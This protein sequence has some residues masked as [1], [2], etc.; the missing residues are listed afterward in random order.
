[1]K[2]KDY[3]NV[4]LR[5]Q[6]RLNDFDIVS[7]YLTRATFILRGLEALHWRIVGFSLIQLFPVLNFVN[8]V[9]QNTFIHLYLLEEGDV[10]NFVIVYDGI[11]I[12]IPPD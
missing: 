2:T 1:M 4:L 8:N 10:V 11:A 5:C 3:W 6:Y 12:T 7:K 9:I